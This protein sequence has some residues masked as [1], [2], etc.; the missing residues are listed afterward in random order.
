M[1]ARSTVVRPNFE[2]AQ[3]AADLWITTATEDPEFLESG[4]GEYVTAAEDIDGD[5]L[6]EGFAA[7]E[8]DEEDANDPGELSR[9]RA[10]LQALELAARTAPPPG[11]GIGALGPAPSTAQP[12]RG[13]RE[14]FPPG[15]PGTL[16]E[17]DLRLL[18]EAAGAVPARLAN[19]ER[20]ARTALT[21]EAD[22][23]LAEIEAGVAPDDGPTSGDQVLQRLLLVQTQMLAKLTASK[24]K[25]PLE[26][27]LGSGGGKDEGSLSAKGSAARDAYVRLLK[28]STSVAEQIRRLAAEELG[29]DIHSPPASLM[30]TFVEKRSAVG[31]MR[32][33][34]LVSTFAA[35]GW[36]HARNTANSDMEAWMARLLMFT[37]Q[38]ATEGG[39]TQLGWLLTGLPDPAWS[40]LVRR[41]QGLR[42]F[43]RLCPSLW[44]S[45]NVAF[46]KEMEWL[47]T[48]MSNTSDPGKVSFV[49][50]VAETTGTL[51]EAIEKDRSFAVTYSHLPGTA[52]DE[53]WRATAYARRVLLEVADGAIAGCDVSFPNGTRAD[54]KTTDLPYHLDVPWWMQKIGMYHGYPILHDAQGEVR[55]SIQCFGP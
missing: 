36:E 43:S 32:T 46:L 15:Q 9:L 54:C 19:H 41:R 28:D 31:E 55:K 27:A 45:G 24:P 51:K 44:L 53:V 5:P 4:L 40:S 13:A 20:A 52:G 3:T 30:R 11:S 35:H 38:C 10:R 1:K 8:G 37:D 42:P 7:E 47:A 49:P 33:L 23:T 2:A 25:S 34:A 21:R 26:A 6:P 17:G 14:L 18:R 12:R 22:D 50:M 16:S 39:R 29:E 48:R